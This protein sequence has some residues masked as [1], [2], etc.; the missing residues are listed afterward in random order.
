MNRQISLKPQDLLVLL[1]VA[2]RPVSPYT[3]ASLAHEIGISA[4]EIHASLKRAETAR[5]IARESRG[6]VAIVRTALTEFVVHG[7]R[8]AFPPVVGGSTRGMPTA[9]A[10]P[11]LRRALQE[12]DAIPPV[13]PTP[14]G[15]IRGITL[16]PLYPSVPE[17]AERSPDLYAMLALFDA[18][19]IGA[20]RERELAIAG[21]EERLR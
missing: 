21:L 4:S 7:A 18:L 12:T 10:S 19:R 14:K 1:R 15:T 3:Y 11:V 6:R 17:A 13:W 20:A 16:H 5:L 8:Y 9:H 2:I